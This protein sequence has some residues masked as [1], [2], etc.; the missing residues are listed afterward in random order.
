M[1]GGGAQKPHAGAHGANL[2]TNASFSGILRFTLQPYCARLTLSPARL[3]IPIRSEIEIRAEI[4]RLDGI[5]RAARERR[6]I[7]GRAE[8]LRGSDAIE[9]T[10]AASALCAL[11]YALGESESS[12]ER[13][14]RLNR[15]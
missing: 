9:G 10:L 7:M 5:V 2:L 1:R 8:A 12:L 6:A 15:I 3:E 11:A 14:R 13:T 4:A